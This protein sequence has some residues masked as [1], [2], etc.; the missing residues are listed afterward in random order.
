MRTSSS[1]SELRARLATAGLLCGAIGASSC[2]KEAEIPDPPDVS[3]LVRVYESP[4]GEVNAASV[5][6]GLVNGVQIASTVA[7]TG[8][9]LYLREVANRVHESAALE[10]SRDRLNDRLEQPEIEIDA[11]IVVTRVCNGWLDPNAPPNAAQNG[12]VEAH[13]V[14]R[15]D[16][17]LPTV[18]GNSV[19]RCLQS[20]PVEARTVQ[21]FFE[22]S[23]VVEVTGAGE[24]IFIQLAG[25]FGS[26]QASSVVSGTRDFRVL[27]NGQVEVR[28]PAPTGGDVIV[29]F[30]AGEI[31]VR[32]A[33]G[34]FV[35]SLDAHTCTSPRGEVFQW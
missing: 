15:N 32:G 8:L 9:G 24:P 4:D 28:A 21:L 22:G 10:V 3:G 16:L 23:Y 13:G 25:S 5:A 11:S 33:N 18:W 19:G 26:G 6:A 31:G 2:M 12:L 1:G 7:G 14:V 20:V 30:G 27:P 29:F 34:R 35:C 17:P